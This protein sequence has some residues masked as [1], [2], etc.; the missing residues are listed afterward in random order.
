MNHAGVGVWPRRAARAVQAF[1]E[2][3]MRTG[4]RDYAA[5]TWKERLLKES[6]AK[7]I[8]APSP[9]DIALVANTSAALSIVA[10]GLDWKWGDNV[11]GAA[12]EFPSNR[13]PW[14]AQ[15]KWGV[16]YRAV[17]LT[18]ADPEADLLAACDRQ[19]RVLAVSSVQFGTGFRLDLA[20]LGEGCR[21]RGVLF[22]VDAIQSLGVLPLDV[23][24]TCVDFAMADAHKWLLGPE[25]LALFY[26]RSDL[27]LQL[28]LRQFGWHMVEAAGDYDATEWRPAGSARRFECGSPNMT[29][30][31]ALAA[32]LDVLQEAGAGEISRRV[33]ANTSYLIER[34]RDVHWMQPITPEPVNRRAGIVTFRIHGTDPAEMRERLG[35]AGA[36]C[37]HRGG[38]LRF[39]P[40]FYN[41]AAQIDNLR[42]ILISST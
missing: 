38:G 13:I 37:A 1:A 12:E 14:Q 26:C 22:C 17:P 21:K 3:N 35:R 30:V 34:L 4:A 2:E 27:R 10:C 24:S 25:G 39:S 9:D 36:V 23:Q 7:F 31:H 19:T 18:G 16:T 6:L 42:D 40:H 20:R 5:W 28:E 41:T 33:L 29:G 15:R 32:S 11:V 8:N